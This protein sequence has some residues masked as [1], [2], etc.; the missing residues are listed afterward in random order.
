MYKVFYIKRF[1]VVGQS[2]T[3]KVVYVSKK[4]ILYVSIVNEAQRLGFTEQKF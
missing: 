3:G 4:D 1:S 2:K